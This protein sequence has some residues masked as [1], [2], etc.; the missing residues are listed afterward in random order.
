MATLIDGYWLPAQRAD[1]RAYALYRRHYSAAKNARY[2]RVGN[3]NIVGP[4]AHMVLL[5]EAADAVFVWIR[6]TRPRF[7]GQVGLHCSLFRNEGPTRSSAL[8]GEADELAWARWPGDRHWTYVWDEKI[9]SPN[10][11]YSFKMA[12]WR[13]CGRNQ[14]GRLTILE[15]VS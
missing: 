14:D 12:G 6:N 7:D 15:R 1:P 3:M 11:G 10:P 5:T 8:I 13:T 2:R 4:A 9:A